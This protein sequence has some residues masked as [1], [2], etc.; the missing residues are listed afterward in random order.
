MAVPV[1]EASNLSIRFGGLVAVSG[2]DLTLSAGEVLCI[3][4]P[5][6]A[7]KST[8]FNL[9]SGIYRPSSGSVRLAGRDITGQPAHRIAAAGIARTFQSSRLFTDLTLIDNVVIGMHCRTRSGVLDALLRPGSARAE[10][11]AAA[12]RAGELLRLVSPDLYTR[13][14]TLAGS[15]PQADRR[16][17]EIARALAS[18]PKIIMLDEP[19]SG[20]DDRDTDALIEDIHMTM[21]E[22]PGLSYVIIEHDMRLVAALPERVM[23]IDYGEKIAEGPFAE[24]RLNPR[25]QEAYL[26]QKAAHA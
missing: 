4:G 11:E 9:I 22:R 19:S 24:V 7:G 21:A 13:R 14:H 25:V 2:V 12:E 8:L 15:L 16:R 6:G 17:L 10:L 20:M 18:E 3:I 26:G 5:N 1:L 23:V